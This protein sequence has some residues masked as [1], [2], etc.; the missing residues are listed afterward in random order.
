MNI[1]TYRGGVDLKTPKSSQIWEWVYKIVSCGTINIVSPCSAKRFD[2]SIRKTSRSRFIQI[3]CKD[4]LQY[5]FT[6]LQLNVFLMVFWWRLNHTIK[7]FSHC[8][9]NQDSLSTAPHFVRCWAKRSFF[10]AI[11]SILSLLNKALFS[12]TVNL[13]KILLY[14]WLYIK[15]FTFQTREWQK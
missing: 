3:S 4:W 6:N 15:V 1:K 13:I 2:E 10:R 14:V 7:M 12:S 5:R 9:S 11:C 8:W